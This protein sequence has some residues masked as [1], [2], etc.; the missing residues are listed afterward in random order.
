MK[1]A[2]TLGGIGLVFGLEC[3][4]CDEVDRGLDFFLDFFPDSNKVANDPIISA[5]TAVMAISVIES[6]DNNWLRIS[7]V[8]LLDE[9]FSRRAILLIIP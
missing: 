3:C 5:L 1:S 9:W 6:K 2:F 7:T 8:N 4:L